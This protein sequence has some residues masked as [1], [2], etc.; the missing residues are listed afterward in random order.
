MLVI[1]VA[2]RSRRPFPA[3]ILSEVVF[4]FWPAHQYDTALYSFVVSSCDLGTKLKPVHTITKELAHLGWTHFVSK[5]F[6][7]TFTMSPD[8]LLQ[9]HEHIPQSLWCLAFSKELKYAH[10][11]YVCAPWKASPYLNLSF[12]VCKIRLLIGF[13]SRRSVTKHIG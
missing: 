11:F 9:K 12:P 3:E 1:S 6:I 13:F 4:L 8:H 2:V 5:R 10:S 7:T